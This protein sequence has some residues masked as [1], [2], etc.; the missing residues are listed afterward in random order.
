MIRIQ[1]GTIREFPWRRDMTVADVLGLLH[2]PYPYVVVRLN[3]RTVTRPNFD[4][5]LVPD[6][7]ELVLIPMVS[8]G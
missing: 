6:E 8:G 1:G 7:A 4:M 3:G 2:E 5:T